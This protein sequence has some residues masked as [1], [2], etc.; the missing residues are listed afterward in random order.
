MTQ[1]GPSDYRTEPYRQ[2]SDGI[3]DQVSEFGERAQGLTE[4]LA[5]AVKE[6]PY[7]A[8]AIVAGA[9]FTVGA[10]WMLGRQ[11]QHT[12]FEGVRGYLAELPYLTSRYR[13]APNWNDLLRRWW[14]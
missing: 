12:Q 11:R 7:A 6:R 8:L 14:H 1:P 4:D 2:H 10:F 9:A 5:S 13:D 3:I